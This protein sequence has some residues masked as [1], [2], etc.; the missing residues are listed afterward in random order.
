MFDEVI[1]QLCFKRQAWIKSE[2][3]EDD[4]LWGGGDSLP[5]PWCHDYNQ[6]GDTIYF[7]NKEHLSIWKRAVHLSWQ[8]VSLLREFAKTMRPS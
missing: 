4:Y 2:P 7:C 5:E 8:A 1:C 3:S 6:D